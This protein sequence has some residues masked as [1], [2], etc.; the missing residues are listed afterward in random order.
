M[1]ILI[2]GSTGGTGRE[3]L[4]QALDSGHE[5]TAF[6]RQPAKLN[7]I[8]GANLLTIQGDVLSPEAVDNAVPGH[9]AVICAI[10]AGAERTWTIAP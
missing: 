1:K 5:V 8:S 9:D 10:G 2:F 3:L 7:D 4:K 6:A